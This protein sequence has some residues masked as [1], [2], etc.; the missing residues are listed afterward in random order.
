MDATR[1]CARKIRKTREVMDLCEKIGD[2]IG[3]TANVQE[4]ASLDLRR[5]VVWCTGA[6]GGAGLHFDE[7]L[8]LCY[9][10]Q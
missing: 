10:T 5:Q 4:V 6:D 7:T 2:V 9:V 8:V 1:A 3:Y